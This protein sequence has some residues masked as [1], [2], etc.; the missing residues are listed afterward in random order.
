MTDLQRFEARFHAESRELNE[1]HLH[2]RAWIDETRL[3][4]GTLRLIPSQRKVVRRGFNVAGWATI[5]VFALGF[6]AIGQAQ[7][8]QLTPQ[9]QQT[10]KAIQHEPMVE[11][12][13]AAWITSRPLPSRVDD[14]DNPPQRCICC[15]YWPEC[16]GTL[17]CKIS[18]CEKNG[19]VPLASRKA[20]R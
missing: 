18:D 12:I 3:L 2:L 20:V 14:Q 8:K 16:G 11:E 13:R 4:L 5:L 15:C 19:W 7:D 1:R 9:Q 17:C 10:W 6:A